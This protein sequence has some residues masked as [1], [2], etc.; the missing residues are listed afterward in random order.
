[1]GEFLPVVY[2]LKVCCLTLMR[3]IVVPFAIEDDVPLTDAENEA[4][5]NFNTRR[6]PAEHIMALLKGHAVLSGPA[7]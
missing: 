2:L 7:V 4:N 5:K 1:M 6:Q 3:S